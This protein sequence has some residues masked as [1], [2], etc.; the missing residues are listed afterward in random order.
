MISLK[1]VESLHN[2]G[3]FRTVFSPKNLRIE[4][5]LLG[6]CKETYEKVA[7]TTTEINSN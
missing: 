1:K 4:T 2:H 5:R 6:N 3:C 7:L